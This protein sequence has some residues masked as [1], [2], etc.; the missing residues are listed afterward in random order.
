MGQD[1]VEG[2]AEGYTVGWNDCKKRWIDKFSEFAC[3]KNDQWF[4]DWLKEDDSE[5]I[6]IASLGGKE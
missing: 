5:F 4:K 1:K 6:K 2:Y 3:I